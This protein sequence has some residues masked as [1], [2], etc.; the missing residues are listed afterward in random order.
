MVVGAVLVVGAA[1]QGAEHL[2]PV[3]QGGGVIDSGVARA[4]AGGIGITPLEERRIVH[5]VPRGTMHHAPRE[6]GIL[7]QGG[8]TT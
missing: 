4:G 2:V 3:G 5:L 6:W 7:N 8:I 1:P